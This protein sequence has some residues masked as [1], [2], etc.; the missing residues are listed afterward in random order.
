MVDSRKNKTWTNKEMETLL[1]LRNE[2]FE[3]DDIAKHLG[4]TRKSCEM[5]QYSW[6]KN[7]AVK[8][9]KV[10]LD[11]SSLQALIDSWGEDEPVVVAADKKT[12]FLA[13]PKHYLR[14][15]KFAN[16]EAAKEL[17]ARWDGMC[18][19][20]PENLGNAR[21]TK[22][23]DRF[24]PVVYGNHSARGEAQ[25]S[26]FVEADPPK[27]DVKVTSKQT[28]QKETTKKSVKPTLPRP[29]TLEL[30]AK[31]TQRV[32]G[33]TR[34]QG[35]SHFDKLAQRDADAHVYI[36]RVPKI[37]VAAVVLAT[38]AVCAWYVGKYM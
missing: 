38:I 23:I 3:Y 31:S 5:K 21:R 25:W 16:K 17:G 20:I 11:D 32:Q 14:N 29:R 18:W 24:G 35:G 34:E 22:L 6:N 30:S 9:Q 33:E 37:L 36:V 4:R 15:V 12:N 26:T 13:P 19:F 8:P 10:M 27:P 7:I 28:T 1:A 2:G